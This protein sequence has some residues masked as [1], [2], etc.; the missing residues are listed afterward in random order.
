ME[1]FLRDMET[2][3]NRGDE[4]ADELFVVAGGALA[5]TGTARR[6]AGQGRPGDRRG[7]AYGGEPLG[8][9]G[10]PPLDRGADRRGADPKGRVSAARLRRRHDAL[11]ADTELTLREI[12]SVVPEL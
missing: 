5:V 2:R 11:L 1:S 3:L 12:D 9:T 10:R 6:L 7:Q 8:R 4:I